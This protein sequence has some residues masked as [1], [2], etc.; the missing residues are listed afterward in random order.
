MFGPRLLVP[1]AEHP[2][3]LHVADDIIL[4]TQEV[5]DGYDNWS[6]YVQGNYVPRRGILS[7]S[8][9]S[10]IGIEAYIRDDPT[11]RYIRLYDENWL[12]EEFNRYI[13]P[14]TVTAIHY[15]PGIKI[16]SIMTGLPMN[17]VE[18]LPMRMR[19]PC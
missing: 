10:R 16:G 13:K 4:I 9:T 7:M 3:K 5:V 17:T 6:R 11:Q 14:G 2:E 12:A 8:A 18:E 1:D 19:G 15:C